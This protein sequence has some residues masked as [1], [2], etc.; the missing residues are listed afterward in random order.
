MFRITG[1]LLLA[2]SLIFT[3]CADSAKWSGEQLVS[4]ALEAGKKELSYYAE[5]VMVTYENGKETERYAIKEWSDAETKKKREEVIKDNERAVSVSDGKLITVWD[6]HNQQAFKMEVGDGM[7]PMSQREQLKSMLEHLNKSYH[8][9]SMGKEKVG[10]HQTV[11][12]KAVSKKKDALLKQME[13]WVDQSSWMVIKSK[14]DSGAVKSIFE[15]TKLDMAPKFTADTFQLSIP[16]YIPVR[17]INELNP[18]K[19]VSLEEAKQA[20]GAPFLQIKDKEFSLKKTELT[21]LEGEMKRTEISLEYD[22][23]NVSYI[24]ESLFKTPADSKR[25]LGTAVEVRGTTG[26]YWDEIHSLTWDEGGF[27]YTLIPTNPDVGQEELIKI[28][29]GM[30]K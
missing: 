10:E 17:D 25:D 7:R 27:R 14:I 19:L 1:S 22:K 20:A 12:I 3:G 9:E 21:Q 15:Y 4:Q 18:V 16:K 23:N 5:G 29:E 2:S 13:L 6:E 28:A 8:I 26:W 30:S 11:H 24:N